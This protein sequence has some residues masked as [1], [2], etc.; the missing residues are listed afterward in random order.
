MNPW[1]ELPNAAPFVAPDDRDTLT[2]LA[3]RLVGAYELR[4]NMMA[5]PWTGH[6]KG[7]R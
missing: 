2:R 1:L 5:Q 4:L 3:G 6:V 7:Q